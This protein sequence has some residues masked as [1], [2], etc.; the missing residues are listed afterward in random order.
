MLRWACGWTR[1]DRVRNEDV[2]Q[3]APVQLKVR[4]HRLRWYG[5]VLRRPL[6]H[7][8]REAMDFEAQEILNEIG[9]KRERFLNILEEKYLILR[10]FIKLTFDKCSSGVRFGLE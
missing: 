3:I 2:M 7:P 5:H 1:L 9:C 8:I 10:E 6:D 4:E